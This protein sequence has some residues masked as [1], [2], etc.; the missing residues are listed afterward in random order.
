MGL[1]KISIIDEDNDLVYYG[2]FYA[3]SASAA[4]NA[5]NAAV[6]ACESIGINPRIEMT[7]LSDSQVCEITIDAYENLV[8]D[9]NERRF[10]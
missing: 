7:K 1:Y 9:E 8:A 5:F 4:D 3:P 10:V 2:L 6:D